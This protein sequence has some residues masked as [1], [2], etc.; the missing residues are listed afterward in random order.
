VLGVWV[1][2]LPLLTAMKF[3]VVDINRLIFFFDLGVITIPI[4]CWILALANQFKTDWFWVLVLAF[5]FV[6]FNSGFFSLGEYNLC[7]S[8]V[9]LCFSI[10]LKRD[11]ISLEWLVILLVSSIIL[12]R[13]YETMA[14]WGLCLFLSL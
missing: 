1:R 10:L 13:S 4:F 7:Y 3:G 14:F 5:S 11:H 2:T 12:I 9:A 6:F 8:L